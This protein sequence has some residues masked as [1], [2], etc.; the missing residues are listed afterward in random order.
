M[1]DPVWNRQG[2]AGRAVAGRRH[3]EPRLVRARA[4]QDSDAAG[5]AGEAQPGPSR[6]G[7]HCQWA[8]PAGPEPMWYVPA[9]AHGVQLPPLTRPA[10]N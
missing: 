4:A 5:R 8:Q 6:P 9:A 2:G 1:P 7:P 3:A 10:P